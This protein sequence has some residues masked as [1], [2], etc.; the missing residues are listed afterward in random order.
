MATAIIMCVGMS[1]LAAEA[2]TNLYCKFFR[3]RAPIP[4]RAPASGPASA[5]ASARSDDPEDPEEPDGI[6]QQFRA[7]TDRIETLERVFRAQAAP[8]N[9]LHSPSSNTANRSI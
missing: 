7:I 5:P 4:V 8:N 6:A 9:T 1:I 2:A 3:V